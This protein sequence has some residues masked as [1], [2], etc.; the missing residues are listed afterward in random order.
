MSFVR[1]L[2]KNNTKIMAIVVIILM[3][4]FVG[5]SS[6]VYLLQPKGY[7]TRTVATMAGNVRVTGYDLQVAQ[8][9]LE[10]L[11]MLKTDVILSQMLRVPMSNTPDLQAFFLGEL[12]FS[13]QKTSPLLMNSIRRT[14]QQNLYDISEKQINDMYNPSIPGSNIY[15]HCLKTEARSMGIRVSN[16][17][18]GELLGRAIP[19][20][21]EGGS[22]SQVIGSLMRK[23]GITER[24]ILETFGTLMSI[25]Q[26]AHL[27]CSDE[28]ITTRQLKQMAAWDSEGINIEF[29]E[30]NAA[31]FSEEQKAPGEEAIAEQFNKY[32]K[33]F[34]GEI[35]EENPYGFGYK[36][37][38][39]V[40]LQYIILKL[41][42]VNRL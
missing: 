12:L 19:A 17:E 20:L 41:D 8:R 14:I 42:E 40:Q 2:R 29:V 34:S 22:Y 9:E 4:A 25:L 39:R 5:G 13:E 31:D 33:Y 15:W 3:V 10:I 36:L 38:D 1:W 28:D 30:F 21:F 18:V 37:P 6:L 24:Q 35:S 26:Y 7:A 23:N 11:R 32:K 16:E 27:I